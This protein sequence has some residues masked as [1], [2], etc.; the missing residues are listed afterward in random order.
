MTLYIDNLRLYNRPILA[1]AGPDAEW[2]GYLLTNNDLLRLC[3]KLVD[4]KFIVFSHQEDTLIDSNIKIPNNVLGVYAVN[5]EYEADK[6]YPFPFGVQRQMGEDDNRQQILKENIEK[7]KQVKPSKL[8]YIN[9]C[10]ERNEERLPLL[11]F[12]DKDWATTRFDVLSMYFPYSQYQLYLDEIKNHKF[13][14][15]P[16][17]HANCYDTHKIW[18]TLYLRR[19]PVVRD[20]PYFRRL[21]Q[22]FPV[23]Y[24]KGW[25]DITEQLLKDNNNLYQEAQTMSL[26][27]LDLNLICDI[28]IKS[29]Q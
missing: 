25:S 14:A 8:F 12:Q 17:G 23:L 18:E 22:D 19:V 10:V 20:Y 9:C 6:L 3:E 7:D 2:V 28:I 11:N 21:L 27:K 26:K 1:N 24:V 15:C 13:V 16:R 5:A 29:Y 4:N